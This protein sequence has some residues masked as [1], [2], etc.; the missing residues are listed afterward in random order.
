MEN[1]P[2]N[3]SELKNENVFNEECEKLINYLFEDGRDTI[4]TDDIFAK[5]VKTY[6]NYYEIDLDAVN[7]FDTKFI[8]GDIFRAIKFQGFAV[9]KDEFL[10][11]LKKY[12]L[13]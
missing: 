3:Q 8:W 1:T 5:I 10:E 9:T 11:E 6:P 7:A 4:L 12:F 13:K 2:S